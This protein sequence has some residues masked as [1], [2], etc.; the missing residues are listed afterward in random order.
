MSWESLQ[1]AHPWPAEHPQGRG[2]LL[3]WETQEA[4]WRRVVGECG[5]SPLVLEVGA[6]AGKT[7]AWLLATFPALR[8]V[9][10]DR[11]DSVDYKDGTWRRAIKSGAMKRSDKMLDNYRTNLWDFRGRAVAVVAP[12]V[13]GMA[14]VAE[15]VQPDIVYIDASHM[16]EEVAGDIRAALAL[17]PAAILCGDDYPGPNKRG[18]KFT[19][20]VLKAVH[21]V[22]CEHGFRIEIDRDFPR[23]WR[24]F[25]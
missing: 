11:W 9:A 13:G 25:A 2:V 17:F 7:A 6:L 20:D 14:E 19:E 3:G 15:H 16:Y 24:Y 5:A 12:S 18:P 10:V 4:F 1:A 22:A 21:E 8:H 23:V